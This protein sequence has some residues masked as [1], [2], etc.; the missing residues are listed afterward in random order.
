MEKYVGIYHLVYMEVEKKNII[1]NQGWCR[2]NTNF[3]TIIDLGLDE[4]QGSSSKFF[5]LRLDPAL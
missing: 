3:D 1:F 4:T 5:L 2:G